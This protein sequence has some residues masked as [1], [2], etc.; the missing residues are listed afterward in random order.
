MTDPNDVAFEI[1]H[2]RAACA[3]ARETDALTEG[4]IDAWKLLAATRDPLDALST[5]SVNEAPA[6]EC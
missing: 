5:V 1:A 6:G 2:V 4:I 3:T